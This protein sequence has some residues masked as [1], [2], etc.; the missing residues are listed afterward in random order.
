MSLSRKMLKA[1]G[2]E[3]EKIDQII[4]AHVE[5]TD[6]LKEERDKYKEEAE[7]LPKI[8]VE[9][10]ALR[11]DLEELRK[12]KETLEKQIADGD[13]YKEKYDAE[14]KAFEE[15]KKGIDSEKEEAKKAKAYRDLLA[16]AGVSPKRIDSIM[17]ITS[18]DGVEFDEDGKVVGAD[19]HI[20]KIKEDWSEFI[21]TETKT[22]IKTEEPPKNVDNGNKMT[23]EQIDA[24]KDTKER[25]KAMLE[26]KELYGL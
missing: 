3:D 7:R 5:S 13:S 22:G 18:V 17:R 1:M 16:E 15:Y 21:V 20:E 4:E 2:I 8:Q 12:E 10:D 23:K 19:K 9:K 14:H 26:N 24:I 6:A 11:E 25:H